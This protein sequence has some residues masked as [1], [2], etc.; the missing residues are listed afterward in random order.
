MLNVV[1]ILVPGKMVGETRLYFGCRHKAVDFLYEEELQSYVDEG[2]LSLRVAFSRDQ[3]KKIY[4]SDLLREDGQ[5]IWTM[6]SNGNA[7]FYV[8][9]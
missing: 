2:S 5:H 8:C 6:L 4:V 3:E 7:H 1:M 9:G